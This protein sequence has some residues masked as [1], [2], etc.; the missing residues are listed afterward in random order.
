MNI[1]F[2]GYEKSI[3]IDFLRDKGYDVYQT[4]DKIYTDITIE[5]ADFVISYGYL[6]IIKK[7]VIDKFPNRIINLHI[8]Y[9]PYNRGKDPNFWSWIE[10][11]PKGVTIHQIDKGIDTGDILVQKKVGFGNDETLRT[12]YQRLRFEVEDLFIKNWGRIESGNII[13]QKQKG[14]ETYHAKKDGET[15]K[16]FL[17]GKESWDTPVKKLEDWG[18]E[19]EQG[20]KFSNIED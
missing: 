8:S 9:L 6:H 19:W 18:L 15:I 2:L 20:Y 16:E 14:I 4:M 10:N 5:W 1:L 11:T 3:I 13:S 7:D 12:S 17:L